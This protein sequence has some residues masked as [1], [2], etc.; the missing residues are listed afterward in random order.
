MA[1]NLLIVESPAKAK[2]IEKFLGKDFQVKSSFGHIRDLEKAGMGIDIDNQ[3]HPRYVISD[4]KE[5]VVRDL[6]NLASKSEEVWLAT[7]ED[8][9]GEAISWHLCEVL[10]LNPNT[11]KRIVFNE[12]TKPAI[13][14]AVQSPRHVDMNLVDA[15]QARRVLDRIVG[16]ELSPV[17]WRKI[18]VKNN[19]SAGR[20]QSVA[21]RLIA[22]REREINAFEPQSSFKISAIFTATDT[23][24]K[25]V[26]FKAEGGRYQTAEDAEKFLQSCVNALYTVSDIQV[27]PGK[28]TPAPPFT[29]STLQQEASRKL[30]YSVSRTMQIA[31]QLYENGYITY[32]RTDSVNLSN[33]ALNDLT[34]TIKSM[35]GGE[36]HQF[37]RFKNRNESAQEAHEAIRPT[38]MSN[39][40]VE[41]NDWKRLYDLIWKRTMACQMADAQLEKTTAKIRIS[42]NKE[43]LTANGEVIKFDGFLKIYNEGRDDEDIQE[44][45]LQEGMLPPLAVGQELPLV[46]MTGTERFTRPSPRYTEASLVKKLEELGI[47]RPSTYAPTISTILKRGYVEKRDKEGIERKYRTL[48]LKENQ[49]TPKE[50]V[51]ITGAE[52]SKLFPTDLG[53]VVTDFLKQHFGDIMDYGF[54]ARI[55]GEFDE[56]ASGKLQW[57]KLIDDFYHPFKGDV[58]NTIE[59]AERIKGERE[60]GMDPESG[61]PVFARM[62]RFGPMIQIGNADDEEKPRFATLRKGQ[63]IE[64]ISFEEAMDLFK[65]PVTLGEHEGK[66]VSVNIG[67][68]GPY[69]KW[70]DDFI[71]IPRAEDPFSVDMGRAVELIREKQAADAPVAHYEGKPVTKGKGR[72]GPFI[73]WNELFINVPRRYDFDH[74][75]QKDIE[76]LIRAKMEKEANRYIQQWP[77]EKIALEN[78]RW[79]A[80]I[81]F[82]KKMVKLGRKENGE[83]Y[84]PEEVAQLP[85]ETVKKM[86][87]AELPGAFEKPAKKAA[88]KKTAAKKTTVKKAAAKKKTGK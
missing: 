53:L 22:E 34:N 31:Q 20:V 24:G 42:T 16:F 41:H 21:V 28:R 60:L 59:T 14:Q 17:L 3:F 65:L 26:S 84:T 49:L 64:T 4:G 76:E 47:G 80:F 38:Y 72:F 44:D 29:T 62:G 58:D 70:G 45:E 33:T 75:S 30:G 43:E 52:K 86:I 51:E 68:F 85:L 83:K 40:A 55:E 56:I 27:K 32:M 2:T 77:E 36:Y 78:G 73:K 48:L 50:A 35:Y 57:N 61:R 79:G 8:R 39:T 66:E 46:E 11:T 1:K 12:I 10:G 88:A 71:S 5:K 9:E 74:L 87:E 54:T 18:S 63:S 81:R 25:Q 82:G 15:Q 7:D 6:K 19:L 69:V 13:Q 37:R 67:R 23:N